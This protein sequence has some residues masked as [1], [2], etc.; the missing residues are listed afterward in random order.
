VG[1]LVHPFALLQQPMACA[2]SI[3]YAGA[4][5]QEQ[6][7]VGDLL[8][9]KL[10]ARGMLAIGLGVVHWDFVADSARRNHSRLQHPKQLSTVHR[11]LQDRLDVTMA[12]H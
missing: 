6:V 2:A 5:G 7:A 10:V 1:N 11:W 3:L 4:A 8:R 12:M 9:S